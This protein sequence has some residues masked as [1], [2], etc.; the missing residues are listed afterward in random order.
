MNRI[1]YS[2]HDFVLYY[3]EFTSE[4]TNHLRKIKIKLNDKMQ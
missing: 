3:Q 4:H 1:M 2:L